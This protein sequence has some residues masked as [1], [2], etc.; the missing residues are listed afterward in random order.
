MLRFLPFRSVLASFAAPGIAQFLLPFADFQ[1]PVEAFS[2][3]LGFPTRCLALQQEGQPDTDFI[4]NDHGPCQQAKGEGVRGR[5]DQGRDDKDRED[6]VGSCPSHHLTVQDA[7]FD[8]SHD[9][10]RQLKTKT[11]DQGELSGKR[12]VVSDPPLVLDHHVRAVFMEEFEDF[13][14]DDIV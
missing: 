4:E 11:E 7:K 1:H 6:C 12:N 8:E 10:D 2:F 5:G 9:E 14:Q 3:F 13:R